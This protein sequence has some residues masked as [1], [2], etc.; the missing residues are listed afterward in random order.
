[1]RPTGHA[2]ATNYFLLLINDKQCPTNWLA[3]AFFAYGDALISQPANLEST[4]ALS[5]FETA[6]NA[7]GKIPQLCARDPNSGPLIGRAYGRMADCYLQ[8]AVADPNAPDLY[9]YTNA[10]DCYKKALITPQADLETRSEAEAALANAL[11]KQ[12]QLKNPPDSG[13]I[14]EALEHALK[15]IYGGNVKAQAG[16]APLPFWVKYCGLTAIEILE[17]QKRWTQLIDLYDHLGK[18]LPPLRPFF[19]RKSLL[20][21]EQMNRP[22]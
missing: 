9:R 4:N 8:L 21:R 17:K 10:V 2:D 14:E 22:H 11:L 3:R 15:V 1:M 18:K 19:E 16:E 7:F 13:L 20:A 5:R 6:L 12:A